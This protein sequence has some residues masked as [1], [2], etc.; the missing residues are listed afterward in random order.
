[1]F[2][3]IVSTISDRQ[4]NG[5][6]FR[7]NAT[8][9]ARLIKVTLK[10][11]MDNCVY[12]FYKRLTINLRIGIALFQLSIH[13]NMSLTFT[14][15]SKSNVLMDCY[16]SVDLSDGDYELGLM[17]FETYHII[18]NVNSSNNKFYFDEDNKE[19]AIP[20]RSRTK[21]K[22]VSKTCNSTISF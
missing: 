1:L 3:L 13:S 10:V 7:C 8:R 20:E 11:T 9:V 22:Q 16:F 18:S 12:N 19:I 5:T 2:I 14:L 21:Y 17:D 15:I 6:I 4:R